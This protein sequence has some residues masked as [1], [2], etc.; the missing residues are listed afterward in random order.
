MRAPILTCL[1]LLLLYPFATLGEQWDLI[2][3]GRL[4]AVP[5]ESVASEQSVI[6]RNGK[7]FSVEAGYILPGNVNKAESDT[8]EVHDLKEH[9]VMPGF[10]DGHVHFT[11]YMQPNEPLNW[12]QMSD[13][14]IAIRGAKYAKDTLLAGFT[15]VRDMGAF[16]GD[17]IFA[18]RDGINNGNIIGPRTYVAGH[19]IAINGGHGDITH[20]YKQ[21]VADVIRT[22]GVCDGVSEC[23]KVVREQIRRKADHIKLTATAGVLS[24]SASGLEQQFFDDELKAIV[25][26]A[27]LMGVKVAAHA[28]GAEGINA[29]LRA[30]VDAIEHGTFLNE[31]SIQLFLKTGAY[32]S[33]TL[34][35]A[36]TVQPL[37]DNPNSFLTPAQR[38]K[39][40][41]ALTQA[42][43]YVRDAHTAGVNIAFSTDAGVI[44]HG[45]NALE[46]VLLVEWGGM[47]PMEAIKTATINGAD[48][49]GK[50]DELGTI[51]AGKWGDIVAVKGNP[52]EDIAILQNVNFV[53]KAGEV[54][55]NN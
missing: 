53:M 40:K 27:H 26:T 52:L 42:K 19:I 17:S 6:L 48:N 11:I 24:D 2:H 29:S 15:T 51:E 32:L 39:S 50:A 54:Y 7:V 22:S 5:G 3:A 35:A 21:S 16:S 8:L 47:T 4:L 12:V 43:R 30:G 23:R 31:E 45:K 28:H 41:R 33:P 36:A 38:E 44:E 1:G 25:D 20:S 55:K 37:I 46:F 9:F 49:I 18:I 10:I 13:P 34:S 14:D